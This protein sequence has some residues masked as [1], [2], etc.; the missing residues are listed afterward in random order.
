MR[1]FT[2][3]FLALLMCAFSLAGCAS[4][5]QNNNQSEQENENPAPASV[6]MRIGGLKGP[7]SIGMVKLMEDCESGIANNNYD[8]TVTGTADELATSLIKGDLDF[9]AIP[10]NLSSVLYN[11]T[12]GKIEVLAVN[13]LGVL[14][15]VENGESIS[16]FQDLKGKTIYATGK[17]NTP[18]NALR[19]LLKQNGLDMDKDVTLEWKSEPSEVVAA[20]KDMPGAAAMLPQ[21]YVTVAQSNIE[22]LRTAID[23]DEEWAKSAEGSRLVTGVLVGR[24]E[25]IE[26]NPKAVSDFL[27]EYKAST[28]YANTNIEETAKLVEKYGIV[29]ASVAVKAIPECNIT[30]MESD[31]MKS[32]LSGYLNVLYVQNPASVGG[33]LPGD[34]YYYYRNVK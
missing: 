33:K 31:E 9:A 29:K 30:F 15:I 10:A 19:Y 5:N 1:K 17:G 27:D 11:N 13:T 4:Q 6:T 23:M 14:Y 25:F 2:S 22:G 26:A 3:L 24:K 20:I 7:T 16:S 28:E 32:A 8:F 21:P 34:D 12:D 18:E